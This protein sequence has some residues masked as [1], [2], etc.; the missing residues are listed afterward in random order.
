MPSA[1]RKL[2][3]DPAK[4]MGSRPLFEEEQHKL[5]LQAWIGD[6]SRDGLKSP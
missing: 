2:A 3:P 6:V 5:E 1:G 4:K